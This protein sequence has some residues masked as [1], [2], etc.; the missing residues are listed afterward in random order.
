MGDAIKHEVKTKR[1]QVDI[2]NAMNKTKKE[3]KS[4]KERKSEE[5]DEYEKRDRVGGMVAD[6]QVRIDPL[7]PARGAVVPEQLRRQL[8]DVQQR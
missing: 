4:V 2:C 8:R 5:D 6:H 1:V 3:S 7:C